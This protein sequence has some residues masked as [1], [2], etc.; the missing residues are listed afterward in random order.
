MEG[1]LN[2]KTFYE[3]FTSIPYLDR[4]MENYLITK[5]KNGDNQARDKLIIHNIK[6]VFN[7]IK[8]CK[9]NYRFDENDLFQEAIIGMI[10]AINTYDP[11]KGILFRTYA[12]HK[13]KKCIS[14]YIEQNLYTVRIPHYLKELF[15]KI[16]K[17][18]EEHLL[19]NNFQFPSAKVLS[20]KLN[21]SEDSIN[22][23]L[24]IYHS[25]FYSYDKMQES[26]YEF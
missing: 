17:I 13:A 14:K 24:E 12:L 5:A 26:S 2:N 9:L 8:P 19:E 4:E 3:N 21:V 25:S 22:R 23:C 15:N 16:K 1:F 6:S 18:E 7:V 10:K 20:E 11:E